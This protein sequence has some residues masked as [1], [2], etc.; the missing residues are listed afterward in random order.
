M[1]SNFGDTYEAPQEVHELEENFVSW[2]VRGP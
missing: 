2:Q 1:E